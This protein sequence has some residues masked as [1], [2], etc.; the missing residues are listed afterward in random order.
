[1]DVWNTQRPIRNNLNSARQL[2][3]RGR[4]ASQLEL[5]LDHVKFTTDNIFEASVG[6][7][8]VGLPREP[9]DP[10]GRL[11]NYFR[12]DFQGVTTAEAYWNIQYQVSNYTVACVLVD[13]RVNQYANGLEKVKEAMKSSFESGTYP[14]RGKP[15][16]GLPNYIYQIDVI[17]PK[18]GARYTSKKGKIS[19]KSSQHDILRQRKPKKINKLVADAVDLRDKISCFNEDIEGAMGSIYNNIFLKQVVAS[20]L[21]NIP[22]L[23][24]IVGLLLVLHRFNRGEYKRSLCELLSGAFSLVTPFG[25]VASI[26]IDGAILTTDI[27]ESEDIKN[28]TKNES[29]INYAE[30]QLADV[31]ARMRSLGMTD[32]EIE[33]QFAK[34][35]HNITMIE[36]E[37]IV[38]KS[39][40]TYRRRCLSVSR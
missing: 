34:Q 15:Y 3:A 36:T 14:T 10:L 35:G 26:A 24:L 4:L 31:Q 11:N 8:I 6:K 20:L 30:Q 33:E 38:T 17:K 27:I 9:R 39:I 22:M 28:I 19:K 37:T 18:S 25:I 40:T 21:K 23:G 1:M 29:A 2:P 5:L 12:I 32:G 13:P 16:G 7:T